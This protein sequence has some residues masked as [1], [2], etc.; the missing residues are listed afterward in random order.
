ME[1]FF[2]SLSHWCSWDF[3]WNTF[4]GQ[5]PRS[6]CQFAKQEW[7]EIHIKWIH[8]KQKYLLNT[9][10]TTTFNQTKRDWDGIIAKIMVF[11]LSLRNNL[12]KWV[13]CPSVRPSVHTY[14]RPSIRTY[15]RPLTFLKNV[16]PSKST[17]PIRTKFGMR[18]RGNEPLSVCG[19]CL[20]PSL[21]RGWGTNNPQIRHF[22]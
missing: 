2:T 4:A 18:H 7:G 15:V 6:G 12:V 14:V 9:I 1:K 11:R 22:L 8:M 13:R 16:F 5:A 3:I 21:Q 20:D 19:P 10:I 17:G